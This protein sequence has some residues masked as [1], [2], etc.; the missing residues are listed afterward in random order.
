MK[1]PKLVRWHP[2][3]GAPLPPSTNQ[4]I[5]HL[6]EGDPNEALSLGE[7][8]DEFRERSFGLFLLLALLPTFIP[9]PMGQGAFSGGLIALI[10]LQLLFRV[11]HPWL[12]G[13]IARYRI[14]RHTIAS[15]RKYMGKWLARLERL[16][17]PR[18]EV[19]LEHPL[20]HAFTGLLLTILGVLLALPLPLTNYP[21]GLVLLA[22]S[23]AL[24]ERDGRLML[25]GW[26][27][28]LIEISLLAGFSGQIIAMV[29]DFFK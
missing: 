11:E 10:G 25:I 15:F 27:L 7:L 16:T 1:L 4:M 2:E 9:I 5:E 17:R 23:F 3:T 22:Y 14:H 29:M 26:I 8:L 28:G 21:F 6:A 20:A 13:F 12:P 18:S 19:W 24:I